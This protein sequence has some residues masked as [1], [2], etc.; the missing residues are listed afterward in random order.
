MAEVRGVLGA[1]DAA[2]LGL[3]LPHEHLFNDLSSAVAEPSYASTRRLVAAEVGP[4]WQFLLRQDPYCC[5][6]N[7][8]VKDHASVVREVSAFAAAG[9]GTVV[10]ATGSAAIGRDPRALAAVAEATGVNVVMG[11]GAYLEKFE[12][13]RITAVTVE[14][15][16]SRI[17]SELDEGV[18]ETG[19]RAGVIGEV[20]VSPLFTDGERASLRA[21]ALAQAARPSAGLNIHMPGWQ[22]RGHEV[23]DLVLEECGALPSKVALAHSDPSGD[24]PGYQRELL[25]RGVL[26]EFDMIGLDISF[27]GEGVAPTV[28]QTARAVARWVHEGF[29]DQ[30]MVS[31]DLFLKQ[32]WTHNGGNGLVFVPTIFGDLLEAEGVAADAVARLMRDVPARWLTA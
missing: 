27:P 15:Q 13:E 4:D 23:L 16:T 7:V 24:D 14:A 8:A 2:D 32:M 29:G 20:G 22:R 1:V 18:G 10:D 28:S 26:L 12:G 19:I 11:T 31:H 21:A 3:V 25:E 5:A 9:G 17:L 30:I 6:D